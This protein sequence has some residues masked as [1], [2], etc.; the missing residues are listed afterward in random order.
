MADETSGQ[1]ADSAPH[2]ESGEPSLV[3]IVEVEARGLRLDQWLAKAFA[4]DLSRSAAQRLL[5]EGQ[6]TVDGASVRE[7]K[8]RMAGGE[9]VAVRLPEPEPAEPRP[10]AIPLTILFEDEHLVVIDKP[11]GLV[12]HPGAGVGSGTLVNA[13]LHHCGDS[14]SGIGGVKRPGIVHRLDKDTSGV[15]VVAKT[16]RAHRALAESF[17][18]HGRSGGLE[19]AYQAL[20]WGAP[21]APGGVIDA[22][23]G[24]DPRDPTR[25]AVVSPERSDARHAVTRF[26][27]LERFGPAGGGESPA[28]LVECRLETGR[29]HQIRVHM[30]H[31]GHPLI[32]DPEYGR[33][34][35]TKSAKLPGGLRAQVDAFA[36]QALHAYLLAFEHPVTGEALRFE[37]GLPRDLADL[38]RGFRSLA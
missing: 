35:R 30:A 15:M 9:T 37:S 23:L 36:R 34:F 16:D 1:A 33:G 38:V 27:V 14:L 24:R 7:A 6:V 13:L 17:A 8:R 20:V 25:R 12:V 22:S 19:R 3:R 2:N 26:S 4:P 32:G 5:A 18:D 11:A 28:A 10:E 21:R 31:L 29:T